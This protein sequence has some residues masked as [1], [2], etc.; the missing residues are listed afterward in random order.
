[1]DATLEPMVERRNEHDAALVSRGTRLRRTG[2]M[3]VLALL[4]LLVASLVLFLAA[5]ASG[6]DG[7]REAYPWLARALLILTL[8]AGTALVPL[9]ARELV[10][11]ILPSRRLGLAL[12]VALGLACAVALP[13]EA[14]LAVILTG[15]LAA[16]ASGSADGDW[17]W[18]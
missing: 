14:G 4:L 18:D 1:M 11:A 5:P 3:L 17:D 13:I 7:A 8:L 6:I 15:P 16:G 9:A 2:A 10:L 12:S